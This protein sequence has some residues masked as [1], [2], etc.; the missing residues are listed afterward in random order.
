[1]NQPVPQSTQPPPRSPWPVVGGTLFI[2]AWV[3]I[4]WI[5]FYLFIVNGLILEMLLNILRSVM[6]PGSASSPRPEMLGWVPAMQSAIILGGAAGLPA[7]LA[8]FWRGRR[9]AL[10]L[11]FVTALVLSV[12]CGI[13]AFYLLIASAITI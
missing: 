13:Y 11:G 7:G 1:M 12:V 6:V 10:L 3:I 5:L 9:K 4:A 8:F 2:I